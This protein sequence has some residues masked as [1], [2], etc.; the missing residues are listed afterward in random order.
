LTAGSLF[1][2][3]QFIFDDFFNPQEISKFRNQEKRKIRL[4]FEE[5]LNSHPKYISL[6]PMFSSTL[7]WLYAKPSNR[8]DLTSDPKITR[9]KP[10]PF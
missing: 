5:K 2:S 4:F 6:G 10:L 8:Y 3:A 9:R 7:S 1:S